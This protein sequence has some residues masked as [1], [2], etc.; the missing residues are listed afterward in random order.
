MRAELTGFQLPPWLPI[1]TPRAEH[2]MA[3]VVEIAQQ[4][5]N[6]TEDDLWG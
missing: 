3:H 1:P 4:Q 2:K 6:E 5:E